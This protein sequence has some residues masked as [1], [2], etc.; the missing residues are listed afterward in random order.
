MALVAPAA[1]SGQQQ[2]DAT[3][4]TLDEATIRALASLQVELNVARD[5]FNTAIAAVHE[6]EVQQEIRN[7]LKNKRAEI[8]AKHR[9]T[10]LEY[11]EKLFVVSTDGAARALFDRFVK[12]AAAAAPPGNP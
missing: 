2:T 9:S 6:F 4:P 10:E 1:L 7:E 3:T 8:L 12:E 11:Q 5:E